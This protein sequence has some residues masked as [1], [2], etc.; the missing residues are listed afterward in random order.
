MMEYEV[1]ITGTLDKAIKP[2]RMQ[3]ANGRQDSECRA[4][5]GARS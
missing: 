4:I 5:P 2:S 1:E 3:D